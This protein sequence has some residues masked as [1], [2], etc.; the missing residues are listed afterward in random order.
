MVGF[1]DVKPADRQN[2]LGALNAAQDPRGGPRD[3]ARAGAGG[4]STRSVADRAGVPL[5]LV[6]YHF[7]SKR[8]LLAAVLERENDRLLV[9]QRELYAAPGLLA[10]KW[11]TACGFLDETFA[12]ATS[13]CCG[14]CGPPG[15]RT[16]RW[17][18]AGVR[19]WE[20]G[21]SCSSRWRRPGSPTTGWS[22][23]SPRASRHARHQHLSGAEVELLA[24][25]G[26]DEAPHREVL[27][28]IG[29]LIEGAEAH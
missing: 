22:C 3:A 8:D 26:E 14:S 13:G 23:L 4:T 20:G 24:G 1:G 9:R 5:S 10:D 18:S 21:A 28:A 17:P 29:A 19:R 7:G 16:T 15:S 25:V 2:G 11:D 12:R 27:D 6:H